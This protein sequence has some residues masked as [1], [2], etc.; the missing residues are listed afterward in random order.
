MSK[1][2][3]SYR[4]TNWSFTYWLA[5]ELGKLLDAH[6]F[7]DFAGIDESNFESALLRNLRE[8]DAVLLIV[9][10]H[11]FSDRIFRPNDWVRQEIRAALEMNKPIALALYEGRIPPSDPTL[12]PADILPIQKAQGIE[13]YPRYFKAGVHELAAFLDRATPVKMRN[14]A[15]PAPSQVA[16]TTSD[17]PKKRLDSATALA[18]AGDYDRALNLLIELQQVNY[19]PR[20]IRLTDLIADLQ[21]AQAAE[22]RR[23]QAGEAYDEIE[24]LARVN[25]ARAQAAWQEFRR[26]YPDF[27]DDPANLAARLKPVPTATPPPPPVTKKPASDPAAAVRNIIGE[28]FEWCEVPAGKFLYSDDKKPLELPSFYIAKYP[29]TYAQFQIFIDAKDGFRESRWWEGLAA[30]ADHRKQPG[31]QQGKIANH[32]RENV[33]WYDAIA[34]CRWLSAKLGGESAINKPDQWLIRL[35][36]EQE[37]EKAARRKDGLVYPW[38]NEYKVGYA[39]IDESKLDGG[40]YLKQTTSVG[41]YPQGAS[42][43]GVLD[44]SGNV[45]EWCLTERS[46]GKSNDMT[47]SEQRVLRGG[48][49][50][51]SRDDARAAY[52][53]SL[54]PDGRLDLVGFRVVVSSP[55]SH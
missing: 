40:K 38:G 24:M 48:S 36:T 13:F 7:V 53:L 47:N 11:T 49:W 14:S 41:S 10:E 20:F 22:Q 9:T 23:W 46:S 54:G 2:F 39:N 37:W 29:I 43:Y 17:D 32:P 16:A 21:Q 27:T 15:A 26:E 3:I 18:E 28:P 31:N 19:H 25:L 42:P 5:D 51:L 12:L 4:R 6:I 55:F 1:L 30:E 44:M 34:F 45:W 33:S 35:P 50:S 52:R 8:S